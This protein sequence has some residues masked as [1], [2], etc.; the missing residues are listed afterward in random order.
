MRQ[1][2]ILTAIFTLAGLYV[3]TGEL[4]VAPTDTSSVVLVSIIWVVVLSKL[5]E[6]DVTCQQ[7]TPSD[8]IVQTL[9]AERQGNYINS[10]IWCALEPS[11]GVVCACIP[12]LRPLF[13][14]AAQ[15]FPKVSHSLSKDKLLPNLKKRRTWPGSIIKVSDGKFSQISEQQED[16]T[17]FGHGVEVHGG[18]VEAGREEIELPEHGINVK[19]EVTV[20]TFG[21]EYQ[22]RLY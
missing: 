1:Q 18:D 16:T 13:R 15:G 4:R 8:Q 12:S 17:P 7:R 6:E 10:G 22:D 14:L 19:T 9:T 21:L 11:M 5:K 2:I 20:T 3:F